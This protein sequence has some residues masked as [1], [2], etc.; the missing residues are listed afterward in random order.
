MPKAW[1]KQPQHGTG[2]KQWSGHTSVT[3]VRICIDQH[4]HTHPT[5][6]GRTEEQAVHEVGSGSEIAFVTMAVTLAAA[7]PARHMISMRMAQSL[8]WGLNPGPS[9]YRTDALPLSYRGF[10]VC[11]LFLC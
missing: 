1:R 4:T 11:Y 3:S 6:Q 10:D 7:L 2:Q 5:A 8:H 9:V